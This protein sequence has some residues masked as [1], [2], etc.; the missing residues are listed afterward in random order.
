MKKT[1]QENTWVAWMFAMLT[2]ALLGG[3]LS[4]L[5]PA[6]YRAQATVVV[7]FNIEET[8]AGL[9]DNEIFYFLEREARKLEEL[10]LADETLLPFVTDSALTI[11]SLRGGVLELSQPKDG[12]WHF[13]ATA[14]TPS[15]AADLASRWAISF[16]EQASTDIE[17]ENQLSAINKQLENSPSDQNLLLEKLDLE[18]QSKGLLAGTNISISQSDDLPVEK[19][20]QPAYFILAGALLGLFL[21]LLW[22]ATPFGRKRD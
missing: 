2:G 16:A 15:Q 11:E 8:W 21:S 9:P 4:L 1:F 7:D 22:Q 18:K 5:L 19:L 14:V 6:S 20:G 3:S 10:A 12:G 13:Y 17:I